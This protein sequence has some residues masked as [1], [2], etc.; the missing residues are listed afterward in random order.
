VSERRDRDA[1][2][3]PALRL[4]TLLQLEAQR[5]GCGPDWR[6]YVAGRLLLPAGAEPPFGLLAE[7]VPLDQDQAGA[8]AARWRVDPDVLWLVSRSARELSASPI[9]PAV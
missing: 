9:R 7:P 6:A 8:V 2:E 4:G 3:S 5:I 1:S